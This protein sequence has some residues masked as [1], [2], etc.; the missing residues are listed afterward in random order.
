MAISISTSPDLAKDAVAAP[1]IFADVLRRRIFADA[2]SSV[3]EESSLNRPPVSGE[4]LVWPRR[5]PISLLIL[6]DERVVWAQRAL[7]NVQSKKNQSVVECPKHFASKRLHGD[8]RKRRRGTGQ[9]RAGPV[10]K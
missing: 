2:A 6:S 9:C 4:T 5:K 8:T 10:R 3:S 7:L 1:S